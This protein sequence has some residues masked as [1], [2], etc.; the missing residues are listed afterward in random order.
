MKRAPDRIPVHPVVVRAVHY[1]APT[2]I[3]LRWND[4]EKISFLASAL[5]IKHS[6]INTHSINCPLPH[7][8]WV[9]ATTKCSSLWLVPSILLIVNGLS[10]V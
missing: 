7:P 1:S 8:A 9:V 2:C 4:Q 10:M 5:K 6:S 3:V